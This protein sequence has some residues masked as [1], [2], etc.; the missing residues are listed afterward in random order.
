MLK[1]KKVISFIPDG[2]FYYKKAIQAMQR[3]QFAL[4]H[5]YL[6]RATELSPEDPLILMQFGVLVMEQ[7]RFQEAQGILQQAHRLD[8][9]LSETVFYL[10][11]VHAHLN[12]LIEAKVYAEKYLRMAH[13]GPFKDDAEEIIDFVEQNDPFPDDE[14]GEVYL[15]QEQARGFMESGEF[16]KATALLEDIITDY[17]EHWAAYNN[18]ALAYFYVGKKTEAHDV[19]HD[20]L[21]HNKGNLHALCNIAVFY[22]YEKKEEELEELLGLLT[23]MKPYLVEHRY[24]LGAT[25]ALVGKHEEAFPLFRQLHKSGFGGDAGFYFWYA[26]SAYFTGHEMI[27]KQAYATLL[28][29]DATKEGFEPWGDLEQEL[30]QDSVEQDRAFLLSKIQNVYHSERMLGFFLLGKSA[31]KQEILSHPIYIDAEKMTVAEQ[32]FLTNGIR[33]ELFIEANF[34]KSYLRA[35]ET[36]E[37][38]YEA[39]CPLNHE[40]AHLFQMWFTLCEEA[41]K[42]AYSFLNPKALAA[43]ADYM[44]QSARYDHVT[45]TAIAQ[46]YNVSTPTLTKYMNELMTF[47]PYMNE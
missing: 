2:E 16:K 3:E 31:H 14:D 6:K 20:V 12:L 36:T 35:L 18:L 42:E 22:Y 47:L 9:T 45:K 37:K 29:I 8:E 5:K 21:T 15:L 38:L 7:G 46:K 44:F 40:A 26:H 1:S 28:E 32:L 33:E 17:P 11:E 19:L 24:K 39:Y 43:A 23:K 41:M 10:A 34:E 25:F 27:A 4:A 13:E 30:K